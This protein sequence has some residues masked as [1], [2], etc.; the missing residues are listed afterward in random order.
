MRSWLFRSGRAL[1]PGFGLGLLAAIGQA[2]LS[3]PVPSLLA[4]AGLFALFDRAPGARAAARIGWAGGAG[5]FVG[6]MFWIVEPFLVDPVRYGWMAPF[7]L[8]LL[9]GGLALF[10][11]AAFA[12][13]ARLASGW[14]RLFLGAVLLAAAEASRAFVL[15]GFPWALVGYIWIGAPQMQLAALFGP[16]GLTLATLLAAALGAV[17]LGRSRGWLVAPALAAV[18]ILGAGYWGQARLALPEPPATGI[19]LRVVQPNAEQSLKWDPAKASEFLS[20]L[21]TETEAPPAG[22]APDLVIWPETAVPY[23]LNGSE[24]LVAEIDRAAGG[25]P[26][27]FGIVRRDGERLYNSLVVT[28]PG[29]SVGQ[30]YD[31]F[32]LVPF[33][34]YMPFG[35]LFARFGINGLAA[36][37]GG[38]F[39]AGPGPELLDF[40]PAG[41]ALPLI[42][43]EAIFPQ[44]P[45]RAER[46]DWLLN[47]TNDGWFGKISGPYQHLAQ[48]QLRAVEQGLPMIRA[49]NTGISAVIDAKGRE[50]ER[51]ELG[52]QGRIDAALPPALPPTPYARAGDWPVFAL[53][54]LMAL[55]FASPIR[56]KPD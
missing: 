18:A 45:L 42:C 39:S 31:K 16:H 47:V 40:G 27:A 50:L 22:A 14:R 49:A 19:T 13:A 4:L 33:G 52:V 26:V 7:A 23:L 37:Q 6:S 10:W 35:E 48:A 54:A 44:H 34:E 24:T 36:S 9:P 43:Y 21:F 55:A 5:Y 51:L 46:P 2:P 28:G 56:R 11:A 1:A 17:W 25:V 3:L 8:L 20:R 53:I 29:G 15:T 30:I 41:R 32:H 38:S 12:L